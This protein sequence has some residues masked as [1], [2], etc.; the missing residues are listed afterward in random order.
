MSHYTDP[1]K[2]P[3]AFVAPAHLRDELLS[4]VS[5]DDRKRLWSRVTQKIESNS[6]IRSIS[7]QVKGEDMRVWQWVGTSTSNASPLNHHHLARKPR[8]S[9]GTPLRARSSLAGANG[10]PGSS[11]SGAK[12]TV[13]FGPSSTSDESTPKS[14]YPSLY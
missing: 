1:V 6:N 2:T 13:S 4:A 10:T 9:L 14:L 12:R 11:N 8:T 3:E 7:Q 5:L